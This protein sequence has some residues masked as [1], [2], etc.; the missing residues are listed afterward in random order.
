MGIRTDP[1][2]VVLAIANS[3][4]VGAAVAASEALG[5]YRHDVLSDIANVAFLVG[6]L[7]TVGGELGVWRL[8]TA[9]TITSI[10]LKAELL[11]IEECLR[12]LRHAQSASAAC[13]EG[14]HA[15]RQP[16]SRLRAAIARS[17]T[18]PRKEP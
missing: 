18:T 2:D 4:T 7:S 15:C 8:R 14:E 12:H 9:L 3:P 6:E 13:G 5:Q 11:C 17:Q 16:R 10:R 1:L